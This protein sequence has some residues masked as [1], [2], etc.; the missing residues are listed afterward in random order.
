[1]VLFANYKTFVIEDDKTKSK[2]A[3]GGRRVMRT[4]HH[5]CW[6]AKN[7]HGLADELDFEFSQY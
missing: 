4:S 2:K 6:D 7:R 1:M 5:P 3:Q